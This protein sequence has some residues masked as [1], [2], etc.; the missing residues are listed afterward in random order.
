MCG[1]SVRG[2]EW[3]AWQSGLWLVE[4]RSDTARFGWHGM[5]G[6]GEVV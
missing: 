5:Y 3:L 6:Y 2:L 1:W 4:F